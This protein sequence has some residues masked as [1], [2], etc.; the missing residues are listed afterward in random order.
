MGLLDS[1]RA[2]LYA[3]YGD[4]KK[5]QEY[6][7]EAYVNFQKYHYLD[8]VFPPNYERMVQILAMQNKFEEAVA[9]LKKSIYYNDVVA[10][11]I[12]GPV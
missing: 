7:A 11:T 1:K 5:A 2:E 12:L 8:P 9:L 10:K 6:Y 3:Q 4:P